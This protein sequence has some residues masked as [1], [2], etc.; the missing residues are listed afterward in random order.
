MSTHPQSYILEMQLEIARVNVSQ[1]VE[2]YRRVNFLKIVFVLWVYFKKYTNI[3]RKDSPTNR[4]RNF[5]FP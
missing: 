5:V 3:D 1:H 2:E 4:K